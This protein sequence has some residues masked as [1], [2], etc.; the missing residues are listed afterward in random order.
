MVVWEEINNMFSLLIGCVQ[1]LK[2]HYSEIYIYS[3]HDNHWRLPFALSIVI[4]FAPLHTP[5]AIFS[6]R[7]SSKFKLW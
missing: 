5:S 4:L 2:S 3:L 1:E 6:S 7:S